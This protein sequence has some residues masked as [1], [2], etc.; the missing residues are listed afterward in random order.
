MP[1]LFSVGYFFECIQII[2]HIELDSEV[3]TALQDSCG[4]YKMLLRTKDNF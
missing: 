1:S 4:E 2:E 3:T